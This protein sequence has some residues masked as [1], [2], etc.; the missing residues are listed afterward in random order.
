MLDISGWIYNL[1]SIS[2]YRSSSK[3]YKKYRNNIIAYNLK[4]IYTTFDAVKLLKRLANDGYTSCDGIMERLCF[5]YSLYLPTEIDLSRLSLLHQS[6]LGTWG[7]EEYSTL[8]IW[9]SAI[10]SIMESETRKSYTVKIKINV[11]SPICI[12]VQ[13]TILSH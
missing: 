13:I 5:I 7:I 8:M 3:L 6:V 4:N 10:Q 12:N 9:T 2:I 11:N 1:R